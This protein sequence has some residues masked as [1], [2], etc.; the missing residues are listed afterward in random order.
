MPGNNNG[1]KS[2]YLLFLRMLWFILRHN[3]HVCVA[4][5]QRARKGCV[6][7]NTRPL[8]APSVKSCQRGSTRSANVGATT[9]F[10]V[11]AC[12]CYVVVCLKALVGASVFVLKYD[13]LYER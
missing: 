1:I 2:A 7:E 6:D 8:Q 13:A 11:V 4:L 3:V 12:L 10:S 5:V 9:R